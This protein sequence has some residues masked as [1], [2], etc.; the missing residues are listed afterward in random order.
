MHFI[1]FDLIFINL[2]LKVGLFLLKLSLEEKVIHSQILGAFLTV[3]FDFTIEGKDSFHMRLISILIDV[4]VLFEVG[5]LSM[6]T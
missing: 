2:L 5:P 6:T 3:L 4:Q 1:I